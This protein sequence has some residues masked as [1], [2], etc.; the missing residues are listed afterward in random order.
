MVAIIYDTDRSV[1]SAFCNG[2]STPNPPGACNFTGRSIRRGIVKT[3]LDIET[4]KPVFNKDESGWTKET[5]DAAF[6]P[7]G[8]GTILNVPRCYDMPFDRATNGNLEFDSD[9]MRPPNPAN[10][11]NLVGGFFPYNLDPGY[12]RDPDGTTADYSKCEACRNEYNMS[13]FTRLGGTTLNNLTPVTWKDSTY[14]GVAAFDRTYFADGTSL[15]GY[16]NGG[17]GC[18]TIRPGF[19]GATKSKANISFCFESHAEFTYEK[20]QEFFFRGD[21]DIWVFIND[22][23]VIDL[24]GIHNAAPGY[25]DLDTIGNGGVFEKLATGKT[26]PI[27]IFFCER[28]PVQSNMRISTNASLTQTSK[29]T[30][31]CGGK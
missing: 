12:N 21:D 14:T 8:I 6:T 15:G 11:T 27:D 5:F 10:T 20:G 22:R 30:G 4:R 19:D 29:Q 28:D 7:G 9:N 1:N 26:Y 17:T 23:L 16:Y 24:G 25:V 2:L 31:T 13:C 3:D 18:S